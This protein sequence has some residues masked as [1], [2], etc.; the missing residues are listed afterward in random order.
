MSDKN[1]KSL[2]VQPLITD[3]ISFIICPLINTKRGPSC[4]FVLA[5]L[6]RVKDSYIYTLS[7]WC[8]VTQ[9]YSEHLLH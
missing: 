9:K 4:A 3:H 1:Q 6:G 7:P 2:A 8:R 5:A